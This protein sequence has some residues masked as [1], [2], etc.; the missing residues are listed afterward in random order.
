MFT[1][2]VP[3]W[4]FLL[5]GQCHLNSDR[6][7]VCGE[8]VQRWY[9]NGVVGACL[10]FWYGG[11][12]GNSNR[13]ASETECLQTCGKPSRFFVINICVH[14]LTRHLFVN[15][16]STRAFL[17]NNGDVTLVRRH[18]KSLALTCEW[19]ILWCTLPRAWTTSADRGNGNIWWWEMKRHFKCS[20][21]GLNTN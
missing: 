8:Y 19:P 21:R 13:F 5:S 14:F 11:C 3:A 10:P 20:K 15:V 17:Y 18:C 12:G 1:L 4:L 7:F 2:H 16:C 9:Y 6:G